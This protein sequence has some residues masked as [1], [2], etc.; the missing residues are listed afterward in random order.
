MIPIVGKYIKLFFFGFIPLFLFSSG[1]K[2]T[3]D[4]PALKSGSCQ[5]N[6]TGKYN[7]IIDGV[8]SFHNS[9]EEDEWGNSRNN[10]ILNFV[11]NGNAEVQTIEFVIASNRIAQD[12]I[13]TG[14]YRIKTL[15]GLING[16]EGVYGFADIDGSNG[17]PFFI[18]T[19][20]VRILKNHKD[21]I[22]GSLEVQFENANGEFLNIKGSF[23]ADIK[24]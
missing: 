18:K 12:K 16:F 10:L 22:D 19:G 9:E 23:I 14:Y 3:V 24:I 1:S 11:P 21:S 13:V 2:P 20:G 5:F 4:Y 15:N 8:V 17:L 7:L 6:V